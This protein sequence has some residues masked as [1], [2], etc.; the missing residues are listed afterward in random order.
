MSGVASKPPKQ[1]Y[2]IEDSHPSTSFIILH[3]V[4][5]LLHLSRPQRALSV[6]RMSISLLAATV[7]CPFEVIG[8]PDDR[9]QS[10]VGPSRQGRTQAGGT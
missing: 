9:D 6:S 10:V 3:Q 2:F 8:A 5:L 7:N 1:T 4:A